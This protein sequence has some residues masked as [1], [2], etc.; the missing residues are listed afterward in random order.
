MTLA[1]L[2]ALARPRIE[3]AL[4]FID[5]Y[6]GAGY[7]AQTI[8]MPNGSSAWALLAMTAAWPH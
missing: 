1:H 7:I 5:H 4:G 2:P 6:L 3:R 8:G